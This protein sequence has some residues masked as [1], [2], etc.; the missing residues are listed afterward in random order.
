MDE[1]RWPQIA[2]LVRGP[3]ESLYFRDVHNLLRLPQREADLSGGCDFAIARVLLSAVSTLSTALYANGAADSGYHSAFCNMLVRFYPWDTEEEAPQTDARRQALA[4]VLWSPVE[5]RD[6]AD[7]ARRLET[8]LERLR[9]I[10]VNY[11]RP[12]RTK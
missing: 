7:F 1:T 4:E 10:D 9:T 3:L 6:A 8:H 5:T 11:W 2:R 12:P